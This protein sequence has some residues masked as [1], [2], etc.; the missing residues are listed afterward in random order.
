MRKYNILHLFPAKNKRTRRTPKAKENPGSDGCA[1]SIGSAAFICGTPAS[2]RKSRVF[3]RAPIQATE[4]K[5]IHVTVII[6]YTFEAHITRR[7]PI[8]TQ[9]GS[10]TFTTI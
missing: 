8:I 5:G 1:A 7:A 3:T 4:K 9:P 2:I 6:S 10:I